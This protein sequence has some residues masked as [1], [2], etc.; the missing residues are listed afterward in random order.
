MMQEGRTDVIQIS[1][2]RMFDEP[3]VQHRRDD[4]FVRVNGIAHGGHLQMVWRSGKSAAPDPIG[5]C[6]YPGQWSG[7]GGAIKQSSSASLASSSVPLGGLDG[8]AGPGGDD[9]NYD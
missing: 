9:N 6:I 1:S 5:A 2:A 8:R 7:G 3:P 4:K